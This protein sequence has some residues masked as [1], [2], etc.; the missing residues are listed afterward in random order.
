[1]Y[2]LEALRELIWI[3]DPLLNQQQEYIFDTLM[4]IVNDGNGGIYFWDVPGGTRKI[5]LI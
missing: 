3:N 4:K 5:F 1:M 2:Y